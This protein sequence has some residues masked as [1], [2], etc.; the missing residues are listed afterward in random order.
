MENE[1]KFR[2]LRL[3]DAPPPPGAKRIVLSEQAQMFYE[4]FGDKGA[5]QLVRQMREFYWQAR[6][7]TPNKERKNIRGMARLALDQATAMR[8]S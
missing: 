2:Q 3:R 6:Y 4:I 5:I 7:L 1:Y 8:S